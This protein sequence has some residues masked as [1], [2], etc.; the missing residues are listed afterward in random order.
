MGMFACMFNKDVFKYVNVYAHA[1]VYVVA[2]AHVYEHTCMS[3]YIH[4]YIKKNSTHVYEHKCMSKYIHISIPN[5]SQRMFM[6]MKKK[7]GGLI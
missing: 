2:K 1:L 3:K 4:I 7:H 5:I 6:S